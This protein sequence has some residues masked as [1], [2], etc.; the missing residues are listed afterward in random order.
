[1]IARIAGSLE[2]IEGTTALVA[3]DATGLAYE[4]MIPA[5]LSGRLRATYSLDTAGADASLATIRPS[6]VL[7]TLEYLE[8]QGQGTSFIPRLVGF[9]TDNEREF[10]EMFTTVKGLGNRRAL[11]AL[12]QEP[13]AIADAIVSRDVRRLQELPEIGKKL[14]ETIVLELREKAQ[15]F[16]G[17]LGSAGRPAIPGESASELEAKFSPAAVEAISAMVTLGESEA[18]AERMVA[19][20]LRRNGR[21]ATADEILSAAYA[22][23]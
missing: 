17:L 9:A 21:L 12:A 3:V 4:V 7:H 23:R 2:S 19:G 11:R 20:A 1:M 13:A 22:S 18:S 15:R 5:Y 10:F 6:I 8:G 14:A 16:A